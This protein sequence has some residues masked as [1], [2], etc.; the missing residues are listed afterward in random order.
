M[1]KS[2]HRMDSGLFSGISSARHVCDDQFVSYVSNFRVKA[3]ALATILLIVSPAVIGFIPSLGFFKCLGA[4]VYQPKA[5]GSTSSVLSI[6][7]LCEIK[8]QKFALL[9]LN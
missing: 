8:D 6:E 2:S 3:T 4:S 5:L 1:C 7:N 9:V